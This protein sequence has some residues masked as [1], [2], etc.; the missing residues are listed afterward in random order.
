MNNLC[1]F[2]KRT[3]ARFMLNAFFADVRVSVSRRQMLIFSDDC[4]Y[5]IAQGA[6]RCLYYSI[7]GRCS[8]AATE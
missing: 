2:N 7:T 4:F 5:K 6:Q 1:F 3:A 8:R